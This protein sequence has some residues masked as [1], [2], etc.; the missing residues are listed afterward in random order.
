MYQRLS[1]T[2][3]IT[4]DC[5]KIGKIKYPSCFN[6][7]CLFLQCRQFIDS[8]CRWLRYT[9]IHWILICV[10]IRIS[11]CVTARACV[12]L[13]IYACYS[14]SRVWVNKRCRISFFSSHTHFVHH[15]Q[16]WTF[17]NIKFYRAISFFCHA[18]KVL[19]FAIA[20]VLQTS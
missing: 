12:Q 3:R 4:K 16:V 19:F 1:E 5:Y 20:T 6:I 14:T 18:I 2:L 15:C 11:V 13:W 10:C 7:V 9:N 8:F 17:S